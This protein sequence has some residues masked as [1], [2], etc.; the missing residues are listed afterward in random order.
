MKRILFIA[1]L[2]G[3]SLGMSA[4]TWTL[5]QCIRHALE[6]NLS[7]R[8]GEL[9]V[10]QSEI[11]LNSAQNRRL[12]GLSAS[13][14]ESFS[15]GRSLLGNNT[16]ATNTNST[17]SNLHIGADVPVF[18]GFQIKN[19]I[20]LSKLNLAAA[21]A[22]LEK[23]K[24]D[25]RVAVAQS[26]VQV[27]YNMEILEV[28]KSQ[29]EIDSL[30]VVRLTEMLRNG[31]ASAAEL[32][33]QKASHAQST[34]QLTQASNNLRISLLDLSQ[35]LELPNPEG[36]SVVKPSAAALDLRLVGN[37][38][39]IYADAVER[40]ASIQAEKIR[41][42]AADARI[43]VAKGAFLPTISLS[44]GLGTGYYTSSLGS[45]ASFADQM[46]NNFSQQLGLSMSIPIF[47]RMANRNNLRSSQ[48]SARTQEL[49]LENAKK[50]L[51]KEIQQAWYN[52]LASQDRYVSSQMVRDSASE[53]FE[54]VSAKY[55]N[56]K[57]NIT[58]FN[59]AKN[60]L[61]RA[62]SDLVQA[63]YEH[64]FQ[65]RLLDFYRRGELA[66]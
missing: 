54:L 65:T 39:D 4:Q 42:E 23:A 40:K 41:L 16:Y 50:S 32:A 43:A 17:S 52:A 66:F 6:N 14:S 58:E 12:P 19:N 46:K 38:A 10:Q 64:L 45:S 53:S 31:K 30:Q 51:Y 22:D 21:T 59:E 3:V 20:A 61:M 8:Q 24:D 13:V 62:E 15:A 25:I 2:L 56:G 29:V 57:A 1:A 37:A 49:Q 63:R 33:Q 48:L 35:L 47:A 44:G 11:E 55:E 26:Y 18:Q 7:I 34:Y 27:L 28:A 5:E 60:T 9:S 36:F